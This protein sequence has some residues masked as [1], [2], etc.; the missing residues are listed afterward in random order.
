MATIEERVSRVEG[1]YEHVATKADLKDLEI[2]LTR[3]MGEM[4]ADLIEWMVGMVLG[5][6]VAAAAIATAVERFLG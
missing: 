2:R 4:K 5:G 6:M 3:Q 1:G